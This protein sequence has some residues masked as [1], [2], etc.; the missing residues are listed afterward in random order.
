MNNELRT[1]QIF[2]VIGTIRGSLEPDRYVLMG[3]HRDAWV[4]GAADPSSGTSILMEV[5]RGLGR[6]LKA[7]WRPRRTIK[8]FQYIFE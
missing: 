1:R 4:Y 2:N 8:V 5:S 7:G 3:N 6:L